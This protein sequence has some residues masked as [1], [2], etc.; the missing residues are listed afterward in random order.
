MSIKWVWSAIEDLGEKSHSAIQPEM[1]CLSEN[2]NALWD[3]FGCIGHVIIREPSSINCTVVTLIIWHNQGISTPAILF[4]Y[5]WPHCDQNIFGKVM[6]EPRCWTVIFLFI[7][8]WIILLV[9][10]MYH[11]GLNIVHWQFCQ[12]KLSL[13]LLWGK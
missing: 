1:V 3:L 5:F 11:R 9:L 10:Y 4:W 8:K 6:R 13:W 12:L 7:Y 2:T